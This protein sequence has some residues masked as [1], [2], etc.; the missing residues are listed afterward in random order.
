[1]YPLQHP[2]LLMDASAQIKFFGLLEAK[3]PNEKG[4]S[5]LRHQIARQ[6]KGL[7]F[8]SFKGKLV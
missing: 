8:W 4:L 3:L 1:V 6:E 2:L 7:N 5:N